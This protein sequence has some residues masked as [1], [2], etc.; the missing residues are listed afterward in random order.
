VGFLSLA[1]I[2]SKSHPGASVFVRARSPD[3]HFSF[4]DKGRFSHLTILLVPPAVGAAFYFRPLS[5]TDHPT[6]S[7]VHPQDG[8]LSWRERGRQV[9]DDAG[10]S[11]PPPSPHNTPTPNNNP[12]HVA[13]SFLSPSDPLLPWIAPVEPT[14]GPHRRTGVKV[15]PPFRR[16]YVDPNCLFLVTFPRFAHEREVAGLGGSD[17]YA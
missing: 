14:R 3:I 4:P 13:K 8:R 10:V 5:R 16:V 9:Y 11:A 17:V 15:P 12:Q 2:L 6:T 7:P 1:V